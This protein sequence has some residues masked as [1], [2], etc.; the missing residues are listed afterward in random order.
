MAIT[1]KDIAKETGY[2]ISTVS[3]ALNNRPDVSAETKRKVQ[4]VVEAHG[5]VP[6]ANAKQLKQRAANAIC[7]LVKGRANQLFSTLVEQIQN[8]VEKAG[9]SA[10]LHFMDEDE[11]EVEVAKQFLLEKKPQAFAFLGGNIESFRHSFASIRIPSV[12]VTNPA[13]LLGFRN[14]SSV[15][16]DDI[17]GGAMAIRYLLE[18]GHTNIGIL[19]GNLASSYTSHQRME[20]SK[21]SFTEANVLFNQEQQFQKCRFSYESA[22]RNVK[23]LYEKFPAMT[24]L[25]AMSDV[26]AIGAIRAFLDMGLRVPKDISV[27]GYDGIEL[28]GFY[29]PK[30]TTVHQDQT[31]LAE[32]SVALIVACIREGKKARHETIPCFLQIGETVRTVG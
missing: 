10:I 32:K 6:N 2:A 27:I 7:I 31:Q 3:R 15:S 26:M 13:G 18:R 21:K 24:A 28:A 12:L 4:A 29:N 19:G 5:F 14:L 22:Y 17:A 9:Y 11:N 25:F 30:L 1:I 23:A 20:G 8:L 16:S